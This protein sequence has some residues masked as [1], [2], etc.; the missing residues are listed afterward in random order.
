[1]V[2]A[3]IKTKTE[4]FGYGGESDGDQDQDLH[5]L[6]SSAL[7]DQDLGLEIT[8]LGSPVIPVDPVQREEVVCKA[9]LPSGVD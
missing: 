2:G 8:T 9:Q 5:K 4:T 1:L 3:E 7:K 6:N